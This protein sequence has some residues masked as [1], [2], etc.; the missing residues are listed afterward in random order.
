M[1]ALIES[2]IATLLSS[3]HL[4]QNVEID[5]SS[6]TKLADKDYPSEKLEREFKARP[7]RPSSKNTGYTEVQKLAMQHANACTQPIQTPLNELNVDFTIPTI[8]TWCSNCK[9]VVHHDST[10]YRP[11]NAFPSIADSENNPAGSQIFVFDFQ[12]VACKEPPIKFVVSRKKNKVQLCGRSEPLVKPAPAF[13]P[14]SVR[15][16]YLDA[17]AAANCGDVYAGF[18][19]LRTLLEHHMK[20]KCKRDMLDQVEAEDLC[21]EYY[22]KLDEVVA[23]RAA[24]TSEFKLCSKNLHGRTGTYDEFAKTLE[25]IESHFK[26]L[27]GLE[28]LS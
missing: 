6:I 22:S 23:R 24:I 1:A 7:W 3:K 15:N 11:Q 10:P 18:Y 20:A 26:L 2:A 17:L 16:I 5:L 8:E 28:S 27:E 12:C 19:H 9:K 21:Q 14:K 4:Y 13:I 25:K